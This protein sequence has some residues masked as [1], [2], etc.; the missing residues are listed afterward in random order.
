[1]DQSENGA[2]ENGALEDKGM[3]AYGR[4]ATELNKALAEIRDALAAHS[5]LLPEGRLKALDA[6][7]AEFADRR[8]RVAF[9]GEVK[10][11]KSTLINAVAGQELS[12]VAFGPLTSIPVRITWGKQDGW[13][14]GEHRFDNISA[15]HEIMKEVPE[16]VRE[17]VV[18][19]SADLLQLGGQV[20][21]I[22]T[23][24]VGGQDRFDL[25][26]ADTLKSLDTVVLVVRYP[27][28]FTKFTRHLMNELQKDIGKL[29][30]V[31]NLDASC[32][33][34][35]A[36]ERD[37][38]AETLRKQVAG[39]NELH[40]VDA[41]EG[42]RAARAGDQNRIRSSGLADFSTALGAFASSEK[43][44]VAALREAAKRGDFWMAEALQA[45]SRRR[46]ALEESLKTT[47]EWLT[48][49]KRRSDAETETARKSFSDFQGEVAAA[50]RERKSAAEKFADRLRKQVRSARRSWIFS[51]DQQELERSVRAAVDAYADDVEAAS[52]EYIRTLQNAGERFGAAAPV[53][54]RPRTAPLPEPLIAEDRIG[55]ATRGRGQMIKRM[56]LFSWCLPGISELKGSKISE[57][58]ASQAAWAKEMADTA[59]K[60]ARAVLE[61][62]VAD[63]AGRG[64]EEIEEIKSRTRYEAEDAELEALRKHVPMVEEAR[65]QVIRINRE[66]RALFG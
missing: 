44:E 39:A 48:D 24:G 47:R 26:S 3:Q 33:E 31:W 14:V 32:G 55:M 36:D 37:G 16:D 64:R 27:G 9:Y 54:P 23:P 57:D 19:T 34:L 7:L 10:A 20:D 21:L 58:L 18:E 13:W 11:G 8:I 59:E 43:R 60:A 51:A 40:L 35:A 50:E 5:G 66:A 30:V 4:L 41:R 46:A 38:H 1:M 6:L 53:T 49:V 29:F 61:K 45:L 15:L 65:A 56:L 12:P 63:I 62:R 52:R 22:D 2:L 28:L 42:L 25:I 17:V